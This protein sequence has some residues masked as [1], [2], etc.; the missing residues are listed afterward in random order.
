MEQYAAPH[1]SRLVLS[2]DAILPGFCD[3][4]MHFEKIAAEL[5]MVQL[6]DAR[7]VEDVL[8]AVAASAAKAPPGEWVQAFGDDNAWHEERLEERRLPTRDE[9]DAAAPDNPV[10]LYRGWDAAALNTLAID[11]LGEQLLS[12]SG[13]DRRIGLLR[14]A[15]ARRLQ[16]TLRR[17]S[18]TNRLLADAS[19][20]LFQ[21]GVT[22]VVD[23]GLPG[24]FER[25][26]QLYVDAR[27][28]GRVQQRL[29]LMDRF[30]HQRVFA[31]ELERAASEPTARDAVSDGVHGWGLKL[32]VDG[33]FDNAWMRED[34]PQPAPP[35]KRYTSEQLM[36]ALA[37]ALERGWPICFHVMGGGAIDTVIAAVRSFGSG[38][39][40]RSQVSLCHVFHPSMQNVEACLELGIAISVQPLL[41]YVF[42]H[43]MLNA[44]GERAHAANPYRFMLDAGADIAG[45]S[46]VLPCE[47]L[48]GAAVA[49]TRTSRFGTC[50]GAA[51]ALLPLEA[52]SLF[53]NRAGGYV[54]QPLLGSLALGAPADFVCWPKN[55]L[56]TRVGDW[57]ELRA[58]AAAI[59]GELVWQ[60]QKTAPITHEPERSV[61]R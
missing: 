18:D 35:T 42:E 37:L 3:T 10:F 47:P 22:T 24:S 38:T 1:A 2:A 48:R 55:P 13:W 23:P 8:A 20:A 46:D 30:D 52:I 32:L 19:K 12:V 34:E 57:P 4:H 14:S 21:L 26:R 31:D 41:A 54:Q 58:S 60:D 61:S 39:F 7:S 28:A 9:L 45:G 11:T 53:T 59:A 25:T 36:A 5:G 17:P 27:R 49:V 50:L 29:F 43:E 44:W 16:E 15:Q 6:H 33:E 51:Q 40:V 56:G